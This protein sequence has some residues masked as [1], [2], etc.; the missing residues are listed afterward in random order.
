MGKTL[1]T[2]LSEASAGTSAIRASIT[3]NLAGFKT[4]GQL[5][6]GLS[7]DCIWQNFKPDT[8]S[9]YDRLQVLLRLT[10]L[11]D[12]FGSIVWR[13]EAPIE[14]LAFLHRSIGDAVD[15]ATS[16]DALVE[17]L[18]KVRREAVYC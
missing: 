7:M 5:T 16:S 3:Q 8:V 1:M 15:E 18:I 2:D 6:T 11:A 12:H 10:D 14:E 13:L 4:N 9:S 17:P